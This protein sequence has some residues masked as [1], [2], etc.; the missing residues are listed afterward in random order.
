MMDYLVNQPILGDYLHFTYLECSSC[1]QICW[2]LEKWSMFFHTVELM[3]SMTLNELMKNRMPKNQ[4]EKALNA[5]ASFFLENPSIFEPIS[6]HSTKFFFLNQ[7]S[8]S[9]TCL[10]PSYCVYYIPSTVI[11]CFIPEFWKRIIKN[12]DP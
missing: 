2:Y 8:C 1:S 5:R 3:L 6:P 4:Q 12:V 11:L 9:R 7:A 10:S